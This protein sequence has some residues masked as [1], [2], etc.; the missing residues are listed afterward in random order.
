MS[1]S[2]TRKKIMWVGNPRCGSLEDE[3]AAIPGEPKFVDAAS[4]IRVFSTA[5]KNR[6]AIPA[7]YSR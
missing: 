1:L 4:L 3:D 2:E 6:F 7:C 5:L